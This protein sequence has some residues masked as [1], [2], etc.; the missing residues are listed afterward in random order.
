MAFLPQASADADRAAATVDA[1][2]KEEGLR[3]LGWRDVPVNPI[4]WV[5][6]HAR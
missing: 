4:V 1:I 3:P 5:R 6:L 2:A